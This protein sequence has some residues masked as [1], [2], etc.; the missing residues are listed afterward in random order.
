[1]FSNASFGDLWVWIMATE[2][3]KQGAVHPPLIL[4]SA[5][6]RRADLLRSYG[7]D[8][9]V[10]VPPHHEPEHFS[11]DVKPT[12]QAEA[13][14]YFKARSVRHLI[15]EGI[16]IGGD[17]VVALY[18][19]CFGKPMDREDARRILE[20]ITGTTHEVITGVTLLNAATDDRLIAHDV[21]EVTM[22]PMRGRELEAYL[23]SGAWEGKA[24]AYG[25]QDKGDAF[26]ER[27]NGSFTNVV[28]LPMELLSEMLA[29]WNIRPMA[30]PDTQP[31][32]PHIPQP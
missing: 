18:A 32:K 30:S 24:G 27:V 26:V 22:R 12:M 9:R 20:T 21:T 19:K 31:E 16:I 13:L 28:G 29:S 10:I 15:E 14:S 3:E 25:I 6:P 5:S 7:Y 1:L 17:T 11:A 4:A 2:Q 23:D 8:F